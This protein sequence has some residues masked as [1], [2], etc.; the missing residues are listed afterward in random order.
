MRRGQM[1]DIEERAGPMVGSTELDLRGP[2]PV[3]E[4][5]NLLRTIADWADVTDPDRPTPGIFEPE[6]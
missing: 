5:E 2:G 6:P 1:V 4:I 3:F